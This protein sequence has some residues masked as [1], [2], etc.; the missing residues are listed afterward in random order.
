MA[1][2]VEARF[3]PCPL[4]GMAYVVPNMAF[5]LVPK[6]LSVFVYFTNPPKPRTHGVLQSP[7][8]DLAAKGRRFLMVQLV[9]PIH[10]AAPAD[11]NGKRDH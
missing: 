7:P 11:K 3:L 6:R 10:F 2:L 5:T 9:K 4:I 8:C 1:Q